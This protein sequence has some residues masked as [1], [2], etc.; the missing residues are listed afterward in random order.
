MLSK[1]VD[2]KKCAPKLI[3]FNEKKIEKDSDNFRHRKLTLKVRILPFL[4]SF[5]QLTA[6]L[7]NFLRFW[8]LVLDLKEG[9]VECAIVCVKSEVIL[10][11][12]VPMHAQSKVVNKYYMFYTE[13]QD[14]E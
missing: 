3:F 7:K 4:T 8:L 2:N 11:H 5:T 1:N 6:R 9:L 13:K 10:E 12:S 14:L